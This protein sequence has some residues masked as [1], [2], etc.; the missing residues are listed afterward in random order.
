MKRIVV[1]LFASI[2]VGAI[3]TPA[4]ADKPDT[5]EKPDYSRQAL[6]LILRDHNTR[7]P[8]EGIQLYQSRAWTFRWI[9]LTQGFVVNDLPRGARQIQPI[10][11][12]FTLLGVSYPARSTADLDYPH[13]KDLS[14]GERLYRNR[15]AAYVRAANAVDNGR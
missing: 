15:L 4:L 3:A 6:L 12:P 9:P 5:A 7:N 2:L 14:L 10:V 13:P 8:G 11:N 1:V